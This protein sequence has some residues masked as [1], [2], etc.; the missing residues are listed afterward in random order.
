VVEIIPQRGELLLPTNS[1]SLAGFVTPGAP[2]VGA[3]VRVTGPYVLDTNT[4]HD[5]IFPGKNVA[6]W[7]EIHPAWNITVSRRAR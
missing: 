5:L 4:L 7:A 2:P 6:N 3:H 1:A